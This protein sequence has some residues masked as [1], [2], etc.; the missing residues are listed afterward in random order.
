[1][2]SVRLPKKLDDRLEEIAKNTGRTKSFYL[3][4]ALERW[5][6]DYEDILAADQVMAR[7]RAGKEE[8]FSLE[9]VKQH[10]GLED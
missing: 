10:L 1:M 3:R 9:E 8:T 4:E 2:T 7:I 5:I 6:E